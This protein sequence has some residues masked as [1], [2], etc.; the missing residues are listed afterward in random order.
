VSSRY[1]ILIVEDEPL[2]AEDIQGYLEESGFGVVGIA[3]S[4]AMALEMLS[5]TKPDALLLDINLGSG[6]DGIELAGI[7]RQQYQLPF[8]F[9][10]SH[11]DKSTLERA[12][13]TFPAGYL[14]KPFDGSDLMTSLEI[15]LFNH[16]N[17]NALNNH[18]YTLMQFNDK[19]PNALSDR[20]YELLL[21]LKTGVTNKEIADKLFI[22][23]NTVKTHLQHLF[24]KLDVKN[25]TQAIFRIRELM[26]T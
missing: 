23:I 2:I 14:L 6:P 26:E 21:L 20:E 19:L 18:E 7:I 5:K 12:K 4:G 13:L 11:A 8:V 25:R 24:E 22:S 15:A 9:L 16:F 10:T 17:Q 3:N 1:S